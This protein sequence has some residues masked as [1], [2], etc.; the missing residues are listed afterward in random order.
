MTKVLDEFDKW[1]AIQEKPSVNGEMTLGVI[2]KYRTHMCKHAFEGGF[3][4]AQA[5][6][7]QGE[8]V[9]YLCTKLPINGWATIYEVKQ[10]LNLMTPQEYFNTP[11]FTDKPSKEALQ[12]EPVGY[13]VWNEV[14]NE[15][16]L[17]GS[18]KNH[19]DMGHVDNAKILPVYLAPQSGASK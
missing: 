10:E 2:N 15:W 4:S 19:H 17:D 11:L 8:P 14:E 3:N 18:I 5:L 1:L 7:S 13:A 12:G 9:G 6:L 16:D